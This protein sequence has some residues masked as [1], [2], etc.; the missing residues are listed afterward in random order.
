MEKLY[1]NKTQLEEFVECFK[2]NNKSYVKIKEDIKQEVKNSIA[3]SKQFLKRALSSLIKSLRMD[4]SK[5]QLLLYQ[6][7]IETTIMPAVS[8]PL[9]TP[10]YSSW[11]CSRF[12]IGEQY[13]FQDYN[14]STEA[15]ENFVLNEAKQEVL[16][17]ERENK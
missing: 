15:F 17:R 11:N 9:S 8:S 12:Y 5:F 13:P 4:P 6:M 14:S 1:L 7:P 3:N 16:D 10:A 2:S